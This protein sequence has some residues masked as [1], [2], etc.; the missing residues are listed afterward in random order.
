MLNLYSDLKR[1]SP[2]T[3]GMTRT[4]QLLCRKSWRETGRIGERGG[5][6]NV[7]GVKKEGWIG[8]EGEKGEIKGR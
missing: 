6:M 4:C 3:Q 8:K 1:Q 5:G 7:D 2:A